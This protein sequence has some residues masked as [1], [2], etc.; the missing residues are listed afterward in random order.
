MWTDEGRLSEETS[1]EDCPG[2]VQ[3][4]VKGL[5]F[6]GESAGVTGG[7]LITPKLLASC[8]EAQVKVVMGKGKTC[9]EIMD[10][11]KKY[12][13]LEG[14]TEEFMDEMVEKITVYEDNRIEIVW[15]YGDEFE[16]L[17]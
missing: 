12:E 8:K 1:Y 10:F 5:S 2:H 3:H 13:K 4:G 6:N 17:G 9:E 16:N 11:T 14:L 15:R 7:A